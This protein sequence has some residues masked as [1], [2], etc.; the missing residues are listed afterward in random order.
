M[1][2]LIEVEHGARPLAPTPGG[3]PSREGGCPL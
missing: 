3:H 2:I 1:R